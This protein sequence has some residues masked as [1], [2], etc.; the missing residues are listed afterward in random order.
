MIVNGKLV[1]KLVLDEKVPIENIDQGEFNKYVSSQNSLKNF[2]LNL[3]ATKF[4][5]SKVS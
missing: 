4:F 1:D 3:G 2:I 5:F